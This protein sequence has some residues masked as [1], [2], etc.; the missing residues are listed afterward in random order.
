VYKIRGMEKLVTLDYGKNRERRFGKNTKKKPR[1]PSTSPQI[2][3]KQVG[4]SRNQD[5][6]RQEAE[7][8]VA[9]NAPI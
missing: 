2:G 9:T 7:E 3:K 1:I 6:N 4:S 5:I 8:F